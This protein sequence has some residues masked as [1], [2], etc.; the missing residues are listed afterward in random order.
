MYLITQANVRNSDSKIMYP[1]MC[2]KLVDFSDQLPNAM[3]AKPGD[4][5]VGISIGTVRPGETGIVAVLGLVSGFPVNYPAGTLLYCADDGNLTDAVTGP[6]VATV[7]R[8]NGTSGVIYVNCVGEGAGGAGGSVTGAGALNRVAFWTGSSSIGS[9]MDLSV[10][11]AISGLKMGSGEF[12]GV[13]GPVLIP[14]NQIV[15]L[16]VITYSGIMY[17]DA[18][19]EFSLVRDGE[20][21]LGTAYVTNNGSSVSFSEDFGETVA[22]IGITLSAQITGGTVEIQAVSSSLPA[23]TTSLRYLVRRWGT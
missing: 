15:P 20:R 13:L 8:Q 16:T 22:G 18:I 17:P 23:N 10:V 14:F 5:A 9:S 19:I 11:A 3:L 4:D 1:L 2:A 6:S 12:G 21:R 7:L